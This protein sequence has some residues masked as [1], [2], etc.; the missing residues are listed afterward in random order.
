ESDRMA[1]REW[2]KTK[3]VDLVS[4][5][6]RW[7]NRFWSQWYD[8]WDQIDLPLPAPAYHNPALMLDYKRF[9]SSSVI[10]YQKEQI[11]IIR[12]YRPDDFVTHNGTFK[13][14]D[15]YEFC[16]DLDIYSHDNYPCF[17]PVPQYPVGSNLTKARGFKGRF[18]IMEQQTG[19]GGQTYLQRT[20]RPG[21]MS[22]WAFQAIAHGADGLL[23]FRWR[24][25]RQGAEEY[26]FGVL[27]QDNVPRA[28]FEE[29]KKEGRQIQ[30]I[31][32]EILGSRIV[33]DLAVL[34]DFEAE[35][36]FDYQYLTREV[37]LDAEY[38]DFFQAA[39]E[40][41]YNLD[42]IGPQAAFSTYK[43]IITPHLILMDEELAK[44]IH[45][46]VNGGGTFV[47]SAHS[48]VKDRD[49]GMTDQVPP[50]MLS[51]LFGV[52]REYFH[53]YQEPSREK[54]ALHFQDGTVIPIH[55]FADGLKIKT[56]KILATWDQDYL[57]GIPACTENQSGKGK[58]VYYGS[59][60]N[61]EAARYLIRRYAK[62]YQLNPIFAN[63]PKAVEVTR[64]TKDNKNFYFI[65]NHADE[66]VRITPGSG[67]YDMLEDRPF[68]EHY[69]LRPYEYKILRISK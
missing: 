14:I 40:L 39:S 1:F 2:L 30:K 12:K 34:K 22:L 44:K 64:R 68:P 55:V 47:L 45:D 61:L 28:R 17:I 10:S 58:A 56:A 33:S 29:F 50:I 38:T 20:P 13:N 4:L 27:E 9:I 31:G 46:F 63:F 67:Y 57:K 35:W 51:E 49:N 65:L 66:E 41:K 53:C 19:P 62:E 32:P 5:N 6:E 8:N 15:Y 25:A 36:V 11:D 16:R 3:Y 43:R 69:T 48:A 37:N 21:E 23:H 24:T 59:F 54:N 18:M 52:E 7:G 42:F 26:W 60:F